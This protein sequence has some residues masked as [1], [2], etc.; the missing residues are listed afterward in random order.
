MNGEIKLRPIGYVKSGMPIDSSVKWNRWS[1]ESIVEIYE[2]YAEGLAGLEEFSH[3][4]IIYFMHM[5][6]WRRE[7]I[8]L[9]PRR[10][11][12]MPE[13]GV[14]AF[15]GRNRPN[16]IGLAV[17]EITEIKQNTLKVKGLDAYPETPIL[18]I[19]PYDYYDVVKNPRVPNWFKK[20]WQENKE[21]RP[22]WIGP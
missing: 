15:R 12:D 4:F 21:T 17:C 2:E 3:V 1:E 14:F 20:L 8:R 11:E 18:D 16:P 13:V 10:R 5:A 9:R 6:K 22:K 19:K 7:D